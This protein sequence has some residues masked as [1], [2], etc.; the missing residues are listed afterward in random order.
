MYRLEKIYNYIHRI[1]KRGYV[2]YHRQMSKFRISWS[3]IK[4]IESFSKLQLSS[5]ALTYH[6]VF[7]IVPV[8]SLMIAIA[9]GLG[10][11]EMFIQQVRQFFQGQEAV[12]NYLLL[13]ADS[14][15]S[16]TRVTVWLG[17]GIGLILLLYSVFS[18]FSTIDA[19]FNILW[20]EKGRSFKKR[21]KTF[22]F[23]MV[24][25]FVVVLAVALWWSVSSIF[26]D[27]IIQKL[28]V[29]IV[30][31]STYI[32]TLFVAYKFIPNTKVKTN[33]AFLSAVVCGSIF[34]IMQ[35]FSYY[36]IS[37][38]NYRSIYGDLASLMIFLLLIY[39]SWTICLAGSKWNYFLQ[40]AEEQER[41]DDYRSISHKY[42]KFLC[43]LILERIESVYPFGER[44]DASALAENAETVYNLPIHV[45]NDIIKHLI[46]KKII[47]NVKGDILQLSN[48][49]ANRTIREMLTEF[50][51]AGRN[52]DIIVALNKIHSNEGLNSLWKSINGCRNHDSSLL[53]IPVNNIL[54][55]KKEAN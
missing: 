24:L 1:I 28:N 27:T 10:Y 40:K 14:Y 12:S 16:N 9:K 13:Y 47:F 48:R 5:A 50:D 36:I 32:L 26:N 54:N 52:K 44:F 41:E 20:N 43:L 38:F 45:T 33:Y 21:L 17:V 8:M 55:I 29:F 35:Y 46:S 4:L 6:T 19:T 39:F 25:P 15:L 42:H 51:N 49:Y 31:V 2:K 30:S 34:A 7:A 53:N 18:I 22:A 23:I 37:S 3:L 11:D